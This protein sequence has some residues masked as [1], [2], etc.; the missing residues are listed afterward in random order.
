[1]TVRLWGRNAGSLDRLGRGQTPAFRSRLFDARLVLLVGLGGL[2]A[3]MALGG[4]YSA[5][6]LREIR[7]RNEAIR[8]SYLA[9][10]RSLNQIRSDLFVSGTYVRDYL[11]D[12]DQE[13]AAGNRKNLAAVR[14]ELDNLLADYKGTVRPDQKATWTALE[15]G[16]A[17][18]WPA[19]DPLWDWDQ[20][21]RRSLGYE[22]L[23]AEVMPRRSHLLAIADQIG[24][25]NGQ[26]LTEGEADVDALSDVLQR[27]LLIT[28]LTTLAAGGILAWFSI[29]RILSPERQA[30]GHFH[31]A[32][33]ARKALQD[34]SA[35]L[36]SA[37]EEER[38]RISRE[39][40]DEVGQ[41]LSALLVGL[42]NVRAAVG[43]SVDSGLQQQL[44]T[45]R[46]MAEI[47]VREIRDMALLLRPSMLDD[48]GLV[49][50]LQWHAR[51]IARSHLLQVVVDAG[52][53]SDNLSEQ[54]K[55][56]VY[57]VVQE[58]LHN[59]VSHAAATTVRVSLRQDK[60][61]LILS[62]VDDGKG[63]RPEQRGLGLLG[64]RERVIHLGGRFTVDSGPGKGTR[65]LIELP[66]D[67]RS[68][69][70]S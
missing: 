3:L 21:T 48:L 51:E 12:P 46:Q 9:R 14:S 5:R 37:Q 61:L 8:H 68:P 65:I 64:M 56:C 27:R 18:Y 42:S 70:D 19:L 22:Y 24:L 66:L 55:T 20:E 1:M 23:R 25:L 43:G 39:L 58:A 36:V 16:L 33:E 45:L 47:S 4:I 50:A 29:W 6:S 10:N 60:D 40:H 32:I 54:H 38:R 57:R 28:L 67:E 44:A 41:S 2:L 35:Q 53:V 7:L 49:P 30:A 59:A 26:Q 13:S 11:L 69:V 63:F 62:I 31:E 17:Q 52:D 34:L 15:Q